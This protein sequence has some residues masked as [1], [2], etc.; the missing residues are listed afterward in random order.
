MILILADHDSESCSA[1]W[2]LWHCREFLGY[3]GLGT[4]GILCD[5]VCGWAL[6]GYSAVARFGNAGI[7][8]GWALQGYSADILLLGRGDALRL[9]T[10]GI[11]S[12]WVL[13]GWEN[14]DFSKGGESTL[15][16]LALTQTP[17]RI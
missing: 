8:C 15:N 2:Q 14:V 5:W 16:P 3:F 10:P 6:L 13:R 1:M 12:D 11:L 17:K 9:G 7:P 4:A